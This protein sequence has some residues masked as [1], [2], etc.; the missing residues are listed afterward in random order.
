[1][2][3]GS[4]MLIADPGQKSTG[5]KTRIRNTVM[6]HM[7]EMKLRT[8]FFLS[9]KSYTDTVQYMFSGSHWTYTVRYQGHPSFTRSIQLYKVSFQLFKAS[10]QLSKAS[11]QLSKASFQLSKASLQLSKASFQLSKASFQLSKA[12]FQLSKASF[13]LSKMSFQPFITNLSVSLQLF[14]TYF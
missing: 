9:Q 13:Q 10:F 4:G 7:C 1:M 3:S 5:S 11:F 14:K 12:S 2:C 8:S 6:L